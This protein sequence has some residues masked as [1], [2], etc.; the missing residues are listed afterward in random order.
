MHRASRAGRV[1]AV[2][3]GLVL[4]LAGGSAASADGPANPAAGDELGRQAGDALPTPITIDADSLAARW[5]ARTA[6]L[7]LK[8]VGVPRP[9]D[10]QVALP[11]L[12]LA[13]RLQPTDQNLL[14]LLIE[15]AEQAGDTERV[16]SATRELLKLDPFDTVS[17]LRVITAGIARHQTAE[18]RLA[19]YDRFLSGP[20]AGT[21]DESVR[22]RLSLDAANLA[23]EMGDLKGYADRISQAASLDPTNKD[24]A[25]S[26]VLF[27]AENVPG[28][29]VGRME[30]LINLLMADPV[31]VEVHRA[32]ARECGQAGAFQGALRFYQ[33]VSRV[34]QAMGIE[35]G[36]QELTEGEVAALM[37][38]GPDTVVER[39]TI[40]LYRAR[41]EAQT[42]IEIAEA[43][44]QPTDDMDRPEEF[45]IPAYQERVRLVAAMASIDRPV[46]PAE[47]LF[48][49]PLFTATSS[50]AHA[51]LIEIFAEFLETMRGVFDRSADKNNWTL[52]YTE[53]Q[54][55]RDMTTIREDL[56][57][58]R[59]WSGIQIED[60]ETVLKELVLEQALDPVTRA[61]MEGWL[62]FRKGQYAEARAT[63]EPLTSADPLA[64]L[65]LAVMAERTGD[66]EAAVERYASLSRRISGTMA[67]AYSAIRYR[68]LT[69][70]TVP[71][72]DTARRLDELAAG[73]P[74]WVEG[75]LA[76][77]D[78]YQLLIVRPEKTMYEVLE[79]MTLRI[80]LRN[81][82]PAPMAVGPRHP[83]NSR[84]LLGP[85]L[86]VGAEDL[87][88]GQM[89][90]VVNL[91][92]RLR[93]QPQRSI[94]LTVDADAGQLGMS[95]A[96][97]TARPIRVWWRAVQGFRLQ[98]EDFFDVGPG[99][100]TTV[101]G[102][103]SQRV[104]PLAPAS[105]ET[106]LAAI[107]RGPPAQV[108]DAANVLY[109]RAFGL[110]A[111]AAG[112]DESRPLFTALAKRFPSLPARHRLLLLLLTPPQT[113]VSLVAPIEEAAAQ[114]PDPDVQTAVL[115]SR[116]G[117]LDHPW[118][119]EGGLPRD[120]LAPL[121]EIIKA[122][123]EED[124]P[125]RPRGVDP[126]ANRP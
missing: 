52:Q 104:S 26:A 90:E 106:L 25:V 48:G 63:L 67:G 53:E 95:L 119:S 76:E 58:M 32:I 5:A 73:V 60:A 121:A 6:L 37:L 82:G 8:A 56:A 65:G 50:A 2:A 28:D 111:I 68:L 17:Q 81:I 11:L 91:Y 84:L 74:S 113:V 116:I 93:L 64:E 83:I 10:Y 24:A 4:A 43:Q 70:R 66:P 123:I 108:L 31:D 38:E 69:G 18:A 72:T 117:K 34:S 30:L 62:Q 21:F 109:G 61:R 1:R 29:A 42:R 59:L 3:A 22:S 13:I 85:R 94:D 115:V 12:E 45:R 87:P 105:T 41:R 101:A 51:R 19:A 88:T 114:D 23:R 46:R 7:E 86:K 99:N 44:K 107:D 55:K 118:L 9:R 103:V 97:L 92:R 80:T 124:V 14:R 36:L 75:M 112:E 122:R 126:M 15:A 57:W 27:F 96:R 89:L 120:D 40:S 54:A 16:L 47:V 100:V 49:T 125:T 79:P 33:N 20:N 110:G 102:P 35:P 78:R 77:P 98:R 71:R 39:F